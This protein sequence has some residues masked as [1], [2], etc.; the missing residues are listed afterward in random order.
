MT[1][2]S[3]IFASVKAAHEPSPMN[4]GIFQPST[5]IF[6]SVRGEVTLKTTS[7]ALQVPLSPMT[8]SMPFV[9]SAALAASGSVVAIASDFKNREIASVFIVFLVAVKSSFCTKDEIIEECHAVG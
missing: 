8:C 6:T 9:S 5:A 2:T 4:G 7:A 3:P 1:M